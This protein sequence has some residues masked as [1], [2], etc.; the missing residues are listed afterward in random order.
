MYPLLLWPILLSSVYIVSTIE[1]FYTETVLDFPWNLVD[2]QMTEGSLKLLNKLF[3][4]FVWFLRIFFLNFV[5]DLLVISG[6][7]NHERLLG[8]NGGDFD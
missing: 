4:I 6:E 8:I 1:F 2:I 7:N 3:E 5:V